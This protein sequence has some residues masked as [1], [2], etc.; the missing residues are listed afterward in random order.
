MDSHIAVCAPE[1]LMLFS[2]N[3]DYQNIKRDF[4]AGVLSKEELGGRPAGRGGAGLQ[5]LL[6]LRSW[7]LCCQSQSGGCGAG[8][9]PAGLEP[10]ATTVH[11]QPPAAGNKLFVHELSCEY[12]ARVHNLRSYDA[13]SRDIL[14][15][16]VF[17]FTPDTNVLHKGGAWG[18][19]TYGYMRGQR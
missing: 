10:T 14:Q 16:W 7:P 9:G 8:P 6:L 5:Q 18:P 1:V 4:V 3:F 15:R 11:P 13:I 12:A 17:P 2:D 19:S